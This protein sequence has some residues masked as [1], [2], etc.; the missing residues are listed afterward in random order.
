MKIT[1]KLYAEAHADNDAF[2]A[3]RLAAASDQSV[4]EIV[5]AEEPSVVHDVTVASPEEILAETGINVTA[6]PVTPPGIDPTADVPSF[7]AVRDSYGTASV[8][9]MTHDVAKAVDDRAAF[10]KE[11]D[12]T[13]D[14][15]QKTLG[16]VRKALITHAAARVMLACNVPPSFATRSIHQGQGYNVYAMQKVA[17]I[18]R[19]LSD[20]GTMTN[21]INVAVM[22]TLFRFRAVGEVFTGEIAKCCASD[23]IRFTS[24]LKAELVRHTVAASTASTQASS[25]MQALETCGIVTRSGSGRAPV[26]TLTDHPAV[27]LLEARLAA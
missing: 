23:K 6:D 17:D 2:D 3:A 12:P 20:G 21:K 1:N 7:A 15:I 16:G 8:D 14:N 27:A 5:A 13:N 24:K 19:G 11:K 18:V 9:A 26:Y 4:E 10:E 22:K 25:T